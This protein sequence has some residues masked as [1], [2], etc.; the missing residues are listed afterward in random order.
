MLRNWL[1]MFRDWLK[2]TVLLLHFPWSVSAV[3]LDCLQ[4]ITSQPRDQLASIP[5]ACGII[6]NMMQDTL[7]RLA[8]FESISWG[9]SHQ[10]VISGNQNLVL[11]CMGLEW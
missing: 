8:Y 3:V 7:E 2:H 10:S 4:P 5:T 1:S 9:C 6:E 11:F